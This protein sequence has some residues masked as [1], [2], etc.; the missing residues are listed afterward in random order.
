MDTK[1]LRD[2][3]NT[4]EGYYSLLEEKINRIN[5]YK[6]G[7]VE[8]EESEKKGIQINPAP[9][10]Q[11]IQNYLNTISDSLYDIFLI[12]YSM[13]QSVSILLSD[14]NVYVEAL[15]KSSVYPYTQL[16]NML[17]AGILLEADNLYFGKIVELVKE[18]SNNKEMKHLKDYLLDLLI[19]YKMPEIERTNKNFW[20]KKPYQ[21]FEEIEIIAKTDKEGAVQILKKYLQKQWLPTNN[22]LQSRGRW[23]HC[24]YWSF[25]S[26]AIVKIFDL[27]DTT[28]KNLNFYPYDMVHWKQ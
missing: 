18:K 4:L 26:G 2:K 21:I 7:I 28:I 23:H 1:N 20:W 3:D 16:L 15:C 11:V 17:S 14:F 8:L 10:S 22:A 12:K 27:H 13:G 19:N 6:D 5:K 25:E 9:N 24:G